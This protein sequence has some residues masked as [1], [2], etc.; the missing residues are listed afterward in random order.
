[1][2]LSELILTECKAE[3]SHN[4]SLKWTGYNKIGFVLTRPLTLIYTHTP[5]TI[6]NNNK[7]ENGS[8]KPKTSNTQKQ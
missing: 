4:N 3:S 8:D 7:M 2:T 6:I 1:M 5:I